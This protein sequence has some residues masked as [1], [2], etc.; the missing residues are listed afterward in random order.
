MGDYDY[1]NSTPPPR[2]DTSQST[3]AGFNDQRTTYDV[4][5]DGQTVP[6]QKGFNALLVTMPDGSHYMPTTTIKNQP[7]ADAVNAPIGSTVPVMVPPDVDPQG[8]VDQWRSNSGNNGI[9]N[10]ADFAWTWHQKGA[11]D[12]KN[13]DKYPEKTRPAYDA[14]GNFEYGATGAAVGYSPDTLTR[15]GDITHGGTNHPVNTR[16]IQSGSNAI[17]NGGT[18]STTAAPY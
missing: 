16:D 7:Q 13:A 4:D 15:M 9:M 2:P 14:Y 10:D 1:L 11:N 6:D 8:M 18:L 5:L 3:S 17:L 12:Y